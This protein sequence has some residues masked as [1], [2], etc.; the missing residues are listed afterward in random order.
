MVAENESLKAEVEKQAVA[1]HNWKKKD[2]ELNDR[3]KHLKDQE[4]K[5]NAD[6]RK[7]EQK[8]VDRESLSKK[9]LAV[10]HSKLI[11]CLLKD[12]DL[13]TC[14]THTH[15]HTHTHTHTNTRTCTH[16]HTHMHTHY[17]R[18]QPMM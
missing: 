1:I 5:L 10:S 12:G 3:E 18:T 15:A 14:N 6:K 8:G 4:M 9:H 7:L 11:M 2:K 13:Y 16:V 17:E